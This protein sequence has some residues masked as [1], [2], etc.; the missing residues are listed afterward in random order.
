[1]V[2]VSQPSRVA[3]AFRIVE[4]GMPEG[5]S[6]YVVFVSSHEDGVRWCPHCHAA[7][8]VIAEQVQGWR[9]TVPSLPGLEMVEAAVLQ[10]EWRDELRP[11]PFSTNKKFGVRSLPVIIH[12]RNGRTGERLP[13]PANADPVQLRDF[14][15]RTSSLL[16]GSQPVASK[17]GSGSSLTS[18]ACSSRRPSSSCR[19]SWNDPASGAQAP[20]RGGSKEARP[21]SGPLASI[22]ASVSSLSVGKSCRRSCGTA[23]P[24]TAA[25]TSRSRDGASMNRLSAAAAAAEDPQGER[26]GLGDS[27][28][29]DRGATCG[30]TGAGVQAP[31]AETR[32]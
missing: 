11:H 4:G 7:E 23:P 21:S 14:L 25:S 22:A 3:E 29:R 31:A 30:T 32:L 9:E 6:M 2:P 10:D 28:S 5:H 12:W 15:V 20:E 17:A 27:S 26:E 16:V 19:P 8:G 24:G 13:Y 18:D 1:M